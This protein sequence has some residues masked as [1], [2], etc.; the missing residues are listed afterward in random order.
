VFA[1]KLPKER[2]GNDISWELAEE[3][4]LIKLIDHNILE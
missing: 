4:G 1:S 2:L 3:Q